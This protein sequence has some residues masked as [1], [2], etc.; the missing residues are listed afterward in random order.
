MCV[1]V[2][3]LWCVLLQFYI[4]FFVFLICTQDSTAG[5]FAWF[6][7]TGMSPHRCSLIRS[8]KVTHS[9]K[10]PGYPSAFPSHRILVDPVT[11]KANQVR[12]RKGP[13]HFALSDC[14]KSL[15][16]EWTN[17]LSEL[18]T[19]VSFLL[20]LKFHSSFLRSLER[21]AKG[22]CGKSPFGPWGA[23]GSKRGSIFATKWSKRL[24]FC[25]SPPSISCSHNC[26]TQQ[27][28]NC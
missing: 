4:F 19:E 8:W 5:P 23:E 9:G 13:F 1:H 22:P 24:R 25:Q 26:M 15:P 17:L 27:H 28:N 6:E 20:F 2:N 14:L 10:L 7:M 18:W 21:G 11:I 16:F 3:D 12:L